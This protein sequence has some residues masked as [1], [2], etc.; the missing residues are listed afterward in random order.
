MKSHDVDQVLCDLWSTNPSYLHFCYLNVNLV[1]EFTNFQEVING[2]KDVVS[3]AETKIGASFPSAQLV[4]E[5]YH[6]WYRLD[7]SSKSGG[8]LVYV[9][10]SIP[11]TSPILWKFLRFY[12]GS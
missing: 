6:S 10:S 7:T 8:N 2:N 1:R 11:S 3:T 4:F 9:N 12:T 5:G